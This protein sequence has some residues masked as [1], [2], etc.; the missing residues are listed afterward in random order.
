MICLDGTCVELAFVGES[1]SDDDQC[2]SGNCVS[3]V[4]ENYYYCY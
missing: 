1:C 2:Y 3:G 4:C